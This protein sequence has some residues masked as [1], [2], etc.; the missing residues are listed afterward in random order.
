MHNIFV[1]LKLSIYVECYKVQF[2]KDF[3][4]TEQNYFFSYNK[5]SLFTLLIY[6]LFY[7]I[8]IFVICFLLK[9]NL[10]INV[11]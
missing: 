6:L 5:L 11:W 3:S 10:K 8:Y 9:K 7:F 2:T 1:S 4:G